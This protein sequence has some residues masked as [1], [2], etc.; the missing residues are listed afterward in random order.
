MGFLNVDLLLAMSEGLQQNSP[1]ALL[2]K[3]GHVKRKNLL[4]EGV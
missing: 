1:V 4:R 3:H 2:K